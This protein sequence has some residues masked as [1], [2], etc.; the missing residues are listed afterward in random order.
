MALFDP[1]DLTGADAVRIVGRDHPGEMVCP[2]LSTDDLH[3]LA[4]IR[5]AN[6]RAEWLSHM[7]F[8]AGHDE[9][10][11][12]CILRGF[13][14]DA[15]LKEPV[16]E[17]T[18]DAGNPI[19][20]VQYLDTTAEYFFCGDK[21][22]GVDQHSMQA[23]LVFEDAPD[24]Q[25][26]GLLAADRDEALQLIT[27]DAFQYSF[28]DDP[29]T[30]D[31]AAAAGFQITVHDPVVADPMP[32]AEHMVNVAAKKYALDPDPFTRVHFERACKLV[33]ILD[34]RPFKREAR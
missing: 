18:D 30:F 24:R 29:A 11:Q 32:Y 8:A 22:F 7:W 15:C 14:I 13:R 33:E 26:W 10:D 21:I 12:P 31:A 19:I 4:E 34:S 27:R 25:G 5:N 28:F 2:V 16:L 9:H 6:T 17:G 20:T 1:I 23:L 3:L